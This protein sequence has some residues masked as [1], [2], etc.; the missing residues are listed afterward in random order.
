MLGFGP[1]RVIADPWADTVA[2]DLCHDVSCGL[3]HRRQIV[4]GTV[5]RRRLHYALDAH[6]RLTLVGDHSLLALRRIG[7]SFLRPV[8]QGGLLSS[9]TGSWLSGGSVAVGIGYTWGHGTLYYSKDQK[10][11]KFKLSGVSVADV[12]GAGITAE[13]EVYNLTSPADLSGDYSA[14]TAGVTIIEGGS[15]AYLK[16]QKGVVIKLH[17]QTGGLRFN[18]SANGMRLTL[19]QP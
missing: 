8:L 17:S 3:G 12:G 6:T 13:G 11:Y 15:V 4:G 1:M 10:Q 9:G 2:D 7:I 18:L 16:N 14:V 5:G 19:Q